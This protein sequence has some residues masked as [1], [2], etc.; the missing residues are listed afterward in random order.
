MVLVPVLLKPLQKAIQRN[1]CAILPR[2]CTVGRSF[3]EAGNLLLKKKRRPWM[4]APK[5]LQQTVLATTARLLTAALLA[6]TII[7]T[8]FS[9]LPGMQLSICT[10]TAKIQ[11]SSKV[12]PV[13]VTCTTNSPFKKTHPNS[14]SF[15]MSLLT[16]H[17]V[18]TISRFSALYLSHEPVETFK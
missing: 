18:F 8:L 10:F 11:L 13:L 15:Y 1:Q 5:V 9:I 6:R 2:S 4:K 12:C 16:L 3:R 14:L 17:V 7:R